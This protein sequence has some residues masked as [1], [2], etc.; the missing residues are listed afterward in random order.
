MLDF[1]FPATI[2]LPIEL[3]KTSARTQGK[4]VLVDSRYESILMVRMNDGSLS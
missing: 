4:T 1:C 3:L 2:I